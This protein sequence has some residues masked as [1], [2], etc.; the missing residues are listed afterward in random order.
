M[1]LPK[2]RYQRYAQGVIFHLVLM[3]QM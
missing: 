2:I 1:G 3:G